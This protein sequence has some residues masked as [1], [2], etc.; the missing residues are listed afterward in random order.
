MYIDSVDA[1]TYLYLT[2]DVHDLL[3]R[4]KIYTEVCLGSN[5]KD[6]N[7][8]FFPSYLFHLH[9]IKYTN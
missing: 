5:T 1:S 3:K 9:L 6:E 8:Y 7:K 4:I 2:K